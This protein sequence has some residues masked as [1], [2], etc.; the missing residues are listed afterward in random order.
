MAALF[1]HAASRYVIVVLSLHLVT[2]FVTAMVCHGELARA[3]PAP[4]FLTEY[5]IWMSMGGVLGGLFNALLA[6]TLFPTILEYPLVIAIACILRPTTTAGRQRARA[7]WLDITL[8]AALAV[9]C[10]T[11]VWTLQVNGL[12]MDIRTA[13]REA[14]EEAFRQGLIPYIPA[15]REKPQP[16]QDSAPRIIQFPSGQNAQT[17]EESAGKARDR[18]PGLFDELGE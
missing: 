4:R 10:M 7:R 2:F 13:P 6:P 16:Q 18:G 8:P 11:L 9:G 14:Q 5:Y 12:A 3:R 17:P 1:F 15:D